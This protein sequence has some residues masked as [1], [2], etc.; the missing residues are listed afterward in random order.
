MYEYLLY[1][2]WIETSVQGY[3]LVV[4]VRHCKLWQSLL[5]SLRAIRSVAN[6]AIMACM[7]DGTSTLST[8][9]LR[10]LKQYLDGRYGL[11][12]ADT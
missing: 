3:V 6:T 7:A 12:I 5:A 9:M 10:C 11:F 1:A 4:S 8:E 2:M